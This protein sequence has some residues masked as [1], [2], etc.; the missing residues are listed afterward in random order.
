MLRLNVLTTLELNKMTTPKKTN[1]NA[2]GKSVKSLYYMD[3]AH[4]KELYDLECLNINTAVF[5]KFSDDYKKNWVCP[6]CMCSKPKTGDTSTP[7]RA[8]NN[9]YTNIN[10]TRGN[11]NKQVPSDGTDNDELS[12]LTVMQEIRLL[13]QDV[14]ALTHQIDNYDRKLESKDREINDMKLTIHVLTQKIEAQEQLNLKNEIEIIGVPEQGSENLTHVVLTASKKLGVDLQE[15]DIDEVRRAGPKR[16]NPSAPAASKTRPVVV[17]FLR[18]ARRDE[19]LAAAKVRRNL[20]SEHI[21]YG[22]TASIYFN[23]RLTPSNRQLFREARMRAKLHNFSFC[24]IRNGNVYVRKA[25][26]T[27]S[28]KYPAIPIRSL[29]DINVHIGPAVSLPASSSS[30]PAATALPVSAALSTVSALPH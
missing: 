23:E 3:C 25:A 12:L 28:N 30:V 29:D 10:K 22:T 17:K 11:R 27:N 7:I 8:L 14:L 21:V 26:N 4:C 9:T 6:T 5:E 2:C 20:T 16:P 24:W 18:K 13:R 19:V 15:C 1:C